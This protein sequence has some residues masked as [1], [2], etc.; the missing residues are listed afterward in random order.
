[1]SNG[2]QSHIAHG[3][4]TNTPANDVPQAVTNGEPVIDD[5]RV[6]TMYPANVNPANGANNMSDV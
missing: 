1:M 2:C 4:T 3:N 5:A 6:A